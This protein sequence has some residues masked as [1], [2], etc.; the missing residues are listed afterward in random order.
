M[1]FHDSELLAVGLEVQRSHAEQKGIITEQPKAVVASLAEQPPDL[2]AEMVMI[3]VLW[4]WGVANRA[5]VVLFCAQLVHLGSRQA[6]ATNPV[7]VL[8]EGVVASL[9]SPAE[10]AGRGRTADVVLD[11]YRLFAGGTPPEAI[12]NP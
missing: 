8:T 6:V 7:G 9:A 4:A 10:A 12:G 1:L 3:K 5:T 2:A 11:R